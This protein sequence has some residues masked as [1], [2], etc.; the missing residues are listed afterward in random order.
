MESPINSFDLSPE[1]QDTLGLLQRLLG[2]AIADRYADFCRLAAGG[3]DLNVARSMAAHALRELDSMLRRVLEVPMDAKATEDREG[4]E[5]IEKAKLALAALDFDEAA[6]NRAGG[7]L[8]P[9]FS[10]KNQ[11]RKIVE[12]LGLAPDGDV[13][14][15][16]TSLCESFGKAHQR[17]FHHS[18]KVDDEFRAKY[19]PAF[20]HSHSRRRHRAAKPLRFSHASRRRTGRDA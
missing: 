11:I 17:S 18:L 5:K 1:Q 4:T 12:R 13:A 9:R 15:G 20:R 3:F 16:W 2:S 19:Q 8:K 10:H 7:A 14:N 6:I